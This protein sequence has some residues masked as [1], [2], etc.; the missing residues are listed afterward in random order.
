MTPELY[1][2]RESI[3]LPT[4]PSVATKLIELANDPDSQ[5]E[6]IEKL[7]RLDPV[8]SSKLLSIANS[9][10]YGSRIKSNTVTQALK[11][12]GLNSAMS[13]ALSFSL[14]RVVK[15]QNSQGLG[16]ELFWKRS[17]LAGVVA[18]SIGVRLANKINPEELFIAAL[19]QDIAILSLCKIDSSLYLQGASLQKN[20]SQLSAY[21]RKRFAHDH[22]E[23]GAWLLESWNL[24]DYIV[25]SVRLSHNSSSIKQGRLQLSSI[26]ALSGCLADL[27]LWPGDRVI[28]DKTQEM[29]SGFTITG[30]NLAELL[31]DVISHVPEIENLFEVRLFNQNPELLLKEAKS[32]IARRQA[33]E[34]AA[35]T[36]NNRGKR[37]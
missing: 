20:H 1:R 33:D 7:I 36:E 24:P 13:L 4:L 14:V 8:L 37:P 19:L 34:L 23:I 16:Y 2:L 22:A 35:Y 11:V 31:K 30:E 32:L 10:W 3:A 28:Y 17:L 26:V 6:E 27:L 25:E 15:E 12:I 9:V 5:L 21:E 18:R 29:A